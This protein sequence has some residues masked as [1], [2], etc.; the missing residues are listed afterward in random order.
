M[1]YRYSDFIYQFID[2]SENTDAFPVP[3]PLG[4]RVGRKQLLEILYQFNPLVS[5]TW[6]LYCIFQS[7]LSKKSYRSL[8]SLCGPTFRLMKFQYEISF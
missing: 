1:M 6:H 5:I 7:V 3:I 8:E 4:F 2:L